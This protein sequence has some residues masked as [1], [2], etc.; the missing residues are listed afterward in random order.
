[1]TLSKEEL[2]A[3][4]DEL[5]LLTRRN[6]RVNVSKCEIIPNPAAHGWFEANVKEHRGMPIKGSGKYLGHTIRE[7]YRDE[8]K[9]T[10]AVIK[11]VVS[12]I[13][14]SVPYWEDKSGLG[15]HREMICSMYAIS[16]LF[17]HLGPMYAAG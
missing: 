1:M 4:I 10:T 12:S 9:Q 13:N 17:Y 7:D 2:T 3:A 15:T 11:N 5:G 14:R 8:M 6:L 16:V